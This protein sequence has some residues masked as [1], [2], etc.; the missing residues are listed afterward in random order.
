MPS[1]A[2][3]DVYKDAALEKWLLAVGMAL[4]LKGKILMAYRENGGQALSDIVDDNP[5]VRAFLDLLHAN[6][7]VTA[8]ATD[9]LALTEP[10][11]AQP[12]GARWPKSGKEFAAVLRRF[13][14]AM[15]D[16]EIE[17]DV[18]TGKNRDRNIV[19]S[20][21]PSKVGDEA[22]G[23]GPPASKRVTKIKKGSDKAPDQLALL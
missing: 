22:Y 19:A 18:R 16:V 10:F 9:M 7:T 14:Y 15:P 2:L 11:L 6:R 1:A 21:K 13:A 5:P 4:D 12:K 20:L 3:T 17:F 8:T 23:G